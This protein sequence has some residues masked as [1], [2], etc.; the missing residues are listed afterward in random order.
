MIVKCEPLYS[1]TALFSKNQF[2]FSSIFSIC[3]EKKNRTKD[4]GGSIGGWGFS[5]CFCANNFDRMV[6]PEM[7][8]FIKGL[9]KNN[10]TSLLDKLKITLRSVDALVNH[11]EARQATDLHVREWLNDLK[12]AVFKAEDILD[13]ITTKGSILKLEAELGSGTNVS[14]FS[15]ASLG[16]FSDEIKNIVEQLENLVKQKDVLGLREGFSGMP[17]NKL[18]TTSLAGKSGVY[19]RDADKESDR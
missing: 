17:S 6:S 14:C 5:H 3:K 13:E 12:D 4:Y 8:D 19:G 10:D 2:E 9:K 18:Q 11:A 7:L 15:H 16:K 1:L